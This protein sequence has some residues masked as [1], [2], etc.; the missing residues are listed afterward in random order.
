M[1]EKQLLKAIF[2][3][4]HEAIVVVDEE[5][6]II[7]CNGKLLKLIGAA[8]TDVIGLAI[9]KIMPDLDDKNEISNY[10]FRSLRENFIVRREIINFDAGCYKIFFLTDN[11]FNIELGNR[12]S[13][14]KVLKDIYENILNSIDEGIQVAD[15][16]GNISYINPSQQKLDGISTDVIG[17]HWTEIYDLDN[18]TSL[19]LKALNEGRYTYDE[20]QN[21]TT[22]GGKYVSVV[23]SAMPFYS[24]GKIIGAVAIT[25]DFPKFKEMAERVLH[26]HGHI[27]RSYTKRKNKTRE[28]YYTFDQILGKNK[29]I[30]ESIKWGK[31]G[32][33]S[34]SSILI[35]GETGTGKEMFAQ[36]IHSESS[37]AD[38]PFLAINC[39]AIPES[40][41]ESILFGT[42]K[43]AFTGAVDRVGLIELA[44][45]GTLFLDEINSMPFQLQSKLL[46]MVEEKEIMRLGG[47]E[48]TIVQ[49]RT[50]AS[51]NIEP[52]E[53]IEK[54]QLR[55]D[56]FYRLAVISIYL[57]LLKERLDDL[58]ILMN[59]F[60]V[61]FSHDMH[62]RV[63]GIDD[64]VQE[65]FYHYSWPGNIR[66][67]MHCIECAINLVQEDENIIHPEHLP[68]YLVTSIQNNCRDNCN[69]QSTAPLNKA[70]NPAISGIEA[71]YTS[72]EMNIIEQIQLQEKEEIIAAL[73][74][75]RGNIARAATTL[76]L[77]RQRLHY[78]LK[79]Y[80]LK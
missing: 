67:L 28:N 46:R 43:G 24:E 59:S 31:A 38:G 52:S 78:R 19:V 41:L 54:G 68:K 72:T 70:S 22:R 64:E 65:M 77:S 57:P 63:T 39:A 50:L 14:I 80:N 79:K 40:L 20:Y 9:D 23:C 11:H 66:E 34:N 30:Q 37:R 7:T 21:Y 60:I 3:M 29:L 49:V 62:K 69:L 32:A 47:T 35:Y 1:E 36:S 13:K 58:D 75:T 51:C 73:K 26:L 10:E 74:R 33:K 6:K 27:N 48:K 2:E 61:K 8:Y 71:V 45:N 56:L 12:Y 25:K 42:T 4:T 53:A 44:N 5:N 15:I 18:E 76:G 16:K 17:R 55:S